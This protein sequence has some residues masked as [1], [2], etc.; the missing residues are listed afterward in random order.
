LIAG[1]ATFPVRRRR[2]SGEVF[3]L[4]GREKRRMKVR[5]G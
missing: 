5:K 2:V 1:R 3:V 4:W